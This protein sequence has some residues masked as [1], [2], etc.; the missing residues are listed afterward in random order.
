MGN[1][2]E[3]KLGDG[4]NN[5]NVSN[6]SVNEFSTDI[7][8][9]QFH[10]N[11]SFSLFVNISGFLFECPTGGGVISVSPLLNNGF[12]NCPSS[13]QLCGVIQGKNHSNLFVY[14][15]LF[16]FFIFLLILNYL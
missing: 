13:Y 1:S 14:L 4:T 10:C 12:L 11:E 7:V 2:W 6:M 15:F 3:Y 5:F 9:Y 16:N 8:C